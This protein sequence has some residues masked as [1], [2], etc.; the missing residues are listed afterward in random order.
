MA[1]ERNSSK[2][3]N[4]RLKS[5]L[6][7]NHRQIW[8]KNCLDTQTKESRQT[9]LKLSFVI[10][11]MG[12]ITFSVSHARYVFLIHSFYVFKMSVINL[13]RNQ[14][15]C[16]KIKRDDKAINSWKMNFE[17]WCLEIRSISI[18][19]LGFSFT[20]YAPLDYWLNW[21]KAVSVY[22]QWSF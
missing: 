19:P 20:S 12:I 18:F 21:F 8:T 15:E 2:E 5:Y 1:W 6:I 22:V 17:I 9:L 3:N 10:R 11:V 16:Q 7:Q 4:V 13:S 14:V